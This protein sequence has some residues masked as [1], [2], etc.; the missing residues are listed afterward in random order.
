[1]D[2][3]GATARLRLR[4]IAAVCAGNALEFY[5][6]LVYS[7]FA[8]YIGRAYFPAH[9]AVASLLLSLATFG[10][11]FIPRPIGGLVLGRLGDRIGRKPA[12]LL[13]F[14]LMALGLSGLALT[15]TYAK[16]GVAAPILTVMFRLIQGF[17]LGGE[18][19]P[20]TAFLV[21]SAP[22]QRRGLYGA[23]QNSSQGLAILSAAVV[24]VALS[25]LMPEQALARWGW[26]AAF[27]IGLVIVPFGLIVRRSLPETPKHLIPEAAPGA[28]PPWSI[29]MLGLLMIG[30]GTINSYVNTYMVTYAMDTLHLPA[31]TS[32]GVGVVNG[33]T[34]LLFPI[35]GGWLSDRIG[36]RPVM[37]PAALIS[38]AATLPASW[39][40]IAHP[41]PWVLYASM[42]AIM[43]PAATVSGT[44]IVALTESFPARMRCLAIGLTYA[45][46]IAV[47][48]G[49]TQ[50]MVGWLVHALHAPLAP[51]YY[52]MAAT[53]VGII[54][55][56][57]LR[58]SAPAKTHVA[59]GEAALGVA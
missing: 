3:E 17:A 2:T 6:F 50:F 57:C 41:S 35:L 21:E 23:F 29:A 36:R 10:I 12:M 30:S 40:M 20:S 1:M 4:H 11:G 26:R 25:F 45:C 18:V 15:P 24:A 55:Y 54:A 7:N 56:F 5:D 16:I 39:M 51:A 34:A 27:L 44:M 52:R 31:R 47:F 28:G 49:T 46:A 59:A 9:G 48:G 43:A 8:I 19:G 22:A 38:L 42:A 58:E 33:V 14:A 13:S 37:I 32:F 53:A